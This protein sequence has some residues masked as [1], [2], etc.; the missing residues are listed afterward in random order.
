MQKNTRSTLSLSCIVI[1]HEGS[2]GHDEGRAPLAL[3]P[4]DHYR[5]GEKGKRRRTYIASRSKTDRSALAALA[6]KLS[7]ERRTLSLQLE[8]P[9]PS[10][11]TPMPGHT[12]F[13]DAPDSAR[14]GVEK[15]GD[16][17]TRALP[18]EIAGAA[19][20]EEEREVNA[21]RAGWVQMNDAI[22]GARLELT[23]FA[24]REKTRKH[25]SSLIPFP[26]LLLTTFNTYNA[27]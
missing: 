26:F 2:V 17:E 7:Q 20:K 14:R 6:Q 3:R 13:I 24:W 19:W 8:Y 23:L 21:S 16:L 25:P 10:A 18:Q 11:R 9:Y 4:S 22:D 15:V 5:Q 1:I 12:V 27:T